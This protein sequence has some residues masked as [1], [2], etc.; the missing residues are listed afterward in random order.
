MWMRENKPLLQYIVKYSQ[1]KN[2]I[3]LMLYCASFPN[4][5]YGLLLETNM[6]TAIMQ[7]NVV[8]TVLYQMRR[9]AGNPKLVCKKERDDTQEKYFG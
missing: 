3:A 8:L 4:F 1:N 7:G 9:K 6:K 5:F 2:F